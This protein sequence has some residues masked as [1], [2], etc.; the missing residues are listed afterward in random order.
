[1]TK[2]L[3]LDWFIK[4][5]AIFSGLEIWSLWCYQLDWLNWS[6]LIAIVAVAGW[7]VWRDFRWSIFLLAGGGFW[8][9]FCPHF[10]F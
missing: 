1:M 10:F 8:G 4:S 3:K 6:S 5:L 7:L 9:S 2:L